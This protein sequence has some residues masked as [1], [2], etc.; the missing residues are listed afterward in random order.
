G[1]TPSTGGCGAAR[2]G[3]IGSRSPR[4][5]GPRPAWSGAAATGCS[6]SARAAGPARAARPLPTE[7]APGRPVG[8]DRLDADIQAE[9]LDESALQELGVLTVA[10]RRGQ[11]GGGEPQPE[12]GGVQVDDLGV[13]GDQRPGGSF[14][15]GQGVQHLGPAATH[16]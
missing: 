14:D 4:A 12:R 16:L 7:A 8:D 11:P 5:A 6:W 15:P 13:L 1:A 2:G 3:A 10:E 9:R